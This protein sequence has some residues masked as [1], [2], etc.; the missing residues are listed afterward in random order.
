MF[1]SEDSPV[2]MD[3]AKIHA[4]LLREIN[5]LTHSLVLL[6]IKLEAPPHTMPLR[7]RRFNRLLSWW[8]GSETEGWRTW[9][10]ARQLWV[11]VDG[12]LYREFGI[13]EHPYRI[14]RLAHIKERDEHGLRV[15]RD[16]LRV[17]HA[18]L[19]RSYLQGA[20]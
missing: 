8:L 15:L 20:V 5:N 3:S 7:Y 2:V 6:F 1:A 4:E 18:E 11:S 14:W 16:R 9:T 13:R 12:K 17:L 19:S 10:T